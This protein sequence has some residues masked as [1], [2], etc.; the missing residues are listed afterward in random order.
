[1]NILFY[2]A[3]VT[4]QSG[5]SGYFNYLN[6]NNYKFER[7]AFPS[8]QFYN[9][10]FFNTHRVIEYSNKPDI[11]FFEWSTTGE[12]SFELDKIYYFINEMKKNNILPVFLILPRISTYSSNRIS[13]NQLYKISIESGVPLLDLRYLLCDNI[14]SEILRDDVHTTE[15]GAQLYASCILDFIKSEIISCAD[16]I[17][18]DNIVD[19]KI[20]SYDVD[21]TLLENQILVFYFDSKSPDSEVVASLIKGPNTP[22]IEYISEEVIDKKSFFDPWCYYERENFDTLIT[23]TIFNKISNNSISLK[24]SDECPDFS[25]TKTKEIFTEPKKLVIKSIYTLGLSNF[26]Y[27]LL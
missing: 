6:F 8:S 26:S 18:I 21:L 4:A 9:A 10:G 12:N 27:K 25:I 7:L 13:D 23:A 16:N 22:I 15:F 14:P 20:R 11:V 19:Y 2:G 24:I 3:S 1:M 17:K 5:S